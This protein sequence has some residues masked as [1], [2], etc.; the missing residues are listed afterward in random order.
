MI[1][2]ALRDKIRKKLGETTSAFWSN[3][4]LNVYIND[5]CRDLSFRT[6]CIRANT[7]VSTTDCTANTTVA[8]TNEISFISIDPKIYA[9]LEVYFH[10]SGQNWIKLEPTSRTELDLTHA[11]WKDNVGREYTDPSPTTHYNYESE[12]GTP[13]MYYWDR[14]EDLF[15]WWVPTD[16]E[17]TNANNIRIY[18]T[19]SHTDLSGDS[20]EP[21][22][23]EPLQL[24]II[25]YGIAQ[26][27]ED[28]QWLDRGNDRWEKYHARIGAYMA[29]RCR[30]VEDE[31][32]IMKNYKN[33]DWGHG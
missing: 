7:Y 21:T 4:E 24:A 26:G 12:P 23:P 15:G 19:K 10:E 8:G 31:D 22:I 2:S 9:I 28:R 30:E 29:E 16:T 14:E 3:D 6:K 17:Q 27:L 18:Y 11:G 33:V 13:T 1:R 20:D 5:G 32:L 25:D